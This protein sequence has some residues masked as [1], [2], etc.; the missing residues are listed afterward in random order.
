MTR[1]FVI[2]SGL[3]RGEDYASSRS[4]VVF[5]KLQRR[6]TINPNLAVVSFHEPLGDGEAETASPSISG[7]RLI[8]PV[9]SIE[10]M[11]Q[12]FFSNALTRIV[13]GNKYPTAILNFLRVSFQPCQVIYCGR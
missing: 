7:P 2:E 1:K 4:W 6:W 5:S 11:G 9:K 3:A 12:I 10:Y 13:D 8:T